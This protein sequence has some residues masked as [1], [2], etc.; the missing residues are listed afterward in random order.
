ME[1]R[2]VTTT[3]NEEASIRRMRCIILRQVEPQ[4]ILLQIFLICGRLIESWSYLLGRPEI[5]RRYQGMRRHRTIFP[6]FYRRGN[7]ILRAGSLPSP[8]IA[9]HPPYVVRTD[10]EFVA[11]GGR[12][13][14]PRQ[15]N[16]NLRIIGREMRRSK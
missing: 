10:I 5:P 15:N 1:I 12:A 3:Q 7:S 2:Q 8:R 16:A 9:R 13:S 14:I 6:L 4:L 11:G